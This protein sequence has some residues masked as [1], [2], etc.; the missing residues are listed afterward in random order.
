MV[1]SRILS[2][3]CWTP[4]PE[5][6]RVIDR[7]SDAGD[8]VDLVDVDDA[9]LGLLDVVVGCLDE[10]QQD[11]L[12]VFADVAGFGGAVASA[13]AS[14]TL[15]IF[16]SVC[17]VGLSASGGSMS[18]MFDFATRPLAGRAWTLFAAVPAWTRL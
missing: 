8:L 1:P 18:R 11:V 13:I 14:R 15:S 16:A 7:F 5:T 2:N 6:S 17:A 10:L 3:A 9:R 12:D 4:S